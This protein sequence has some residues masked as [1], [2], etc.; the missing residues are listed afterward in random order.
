VEYL[1]SGVA[2]RRKNRV[3]LLHDVAPDNGQPYNSILVKTL[4]DHFDTITVCVCNPSEARGAEKD[5]GS[6]THTLTPLDQEEAI[7]FTTQSCNCRD[8]E[9]ALRRYKAVGGAARQLERKLR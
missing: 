2:L 3:I 6:A 7:C 4:Q 1:E 5:V 8:E 9:E